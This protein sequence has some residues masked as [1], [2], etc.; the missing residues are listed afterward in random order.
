MTGS[1]FAAITFA[2]TAWDHHPTDQNERQNQAIEHGE[3]PSQVHENKKPES[4]R[5]SGLLRGGT[6]IRTGG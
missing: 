3:M 5:P 1:G 6:R 2:R 4:T